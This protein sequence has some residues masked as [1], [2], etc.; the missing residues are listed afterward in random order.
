[1]GRVV[2]ADAWLIACISGE[3]GRGE[4]SREGVG[5]SML[6]SD[7]NPLWD[8]IREVTDEFGVELFDIDYPAGG[9]HGGV[10][11][12]YL[13]RPKG[14]VVASRV[15]AV[16][17]A[18]AEA[19]SQRS[20]VSFEDCVQVSKKLLDLDEQDGFIPEGCVL[21]VS[22]PGVNRRLRLPQHFSGAAGERVR[23]KFK[24]DTGTYRVVTGVLSSFEGDSF[25]VADEQSRE[26]VQVSIPSIKEARVDFK[27]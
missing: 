3:N 16:A 9:G 8:T 27:F 14:A 21:E 24:T 2:T 20:G 22:S 26:D 7:S 5:C 4:E 23:I 25:S 18:D 17:V 11:R 6:K 1:L 13:S 15:D 19:D 10:L 12:V